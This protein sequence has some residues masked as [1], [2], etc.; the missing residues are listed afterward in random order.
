MLRPLSLP[1]LAGAAFVVTACGDAVTA[2]PESAD[3][4]RGDSDEAVIDDL[5]D[6]PVA[7]AA[8]APGKSADPRLVTLGER[9]FFDHN[10]SLGGNQ[11]CASCHDPEWGFSGP[12]VAF[13]AGGA[14]HEGSVPGR[15]GNRRPPTAAYATPSPVFGFNAGRFGGGN[16]WDGRATGELLGNPAAD[17]ALG[18]F[19]NAV[20]QAL[21]DPACVV[22]RVGQAHYAGLYRSLWGKEILTIGF[23]SSMDALCAVE[24]DWIPLSAE[25]RASIDREYEQI[26]L[27]IAAFEDSR[28]VN[29]FASTYDR[30]LAGRGRLGEE[31][32]RGLELFNGTAR[33]SACHPSAGSRALFTRFSYANIGV[34]ANP[35]NPALLADLGF[36]DFG[37][38]AF[39]LT[40][41]EWAGMAAGEMGK[42]KIPTL[43]NVD[44][45]P[46]A[47]AAKAYMHN[48]YFKSLEQV[49]NFY[50]TRDVKPTCPGPYTAG[51]AVAAACWPAAEVSAN[52]TRFGVGDLGLTAA[53]EDAIVAFLKTLSDR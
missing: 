28:R 35:E 51:E 23:P 37:L 10:L 27:T 18:P 19:L 17:Q 20:E 36:V 5:E 7:A 25:D 43:R 45:R 8:W 11:A 6:V 16:F 22:F 32:T 3:L 29:R 34:P 24:G 41:P 49:V 52:V 53:E 13:N 21:R 33:C 2:P 48:G 9:I 26:A 42:Q 1:L 4:T 14:V 38:G 46:F 44:K 30:Y 50:N 15:F 47:G 31:E 39:L 12:V 40:R